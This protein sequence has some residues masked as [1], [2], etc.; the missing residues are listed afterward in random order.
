MQTT[1][2]VGEPGKK[3]N[4]DYGTLMEYGCVEGV[5]GRWEVTRSMRD[6]SG[7]GL[8][9]WSDGGTD[10]V[11]ICWIIIGEQI[12]DERSSSNGGGCSA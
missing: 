1:G 6:P 2:D 3:L 4:V 11:L 5:T 12:A 9:M 7:V 8:T 10:Q